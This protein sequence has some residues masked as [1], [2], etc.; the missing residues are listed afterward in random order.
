MSLCNQQKPC[1]GHINRHH[2]PTHIPRLSLLIEIELIAV[3][4]SHLAI[5]LIGL[6]A[7]LGSITGGITLIYLVLHLMKRNLP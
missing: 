6:E 1:D 7:F 2:T 4:G 5:G 3:F